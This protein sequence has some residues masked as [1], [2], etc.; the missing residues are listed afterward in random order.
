MLRANQGSKNP[1]KEFRFASILLVCF[2]NGDVEKQ[3]LH[4]ESAN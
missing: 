2:P 3:I 4:S 1:G